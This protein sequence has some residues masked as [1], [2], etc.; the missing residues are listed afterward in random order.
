MHRP[1]AHM[2]RHGAADTISG[3]IPTAVSQSQPSAR[4]V[5]ATANPATARTRR[6]P[7][8]DGKLPVRL[9]V[10][11]PDGGFAISML[12]IP[13]LHLLAHV[14]RPTISPEPCEHR[15]YAVH[16][17]APPLLADRPC[18]VRS[19]SDAISGP[20]HSAAP[21]LRATSRPSGSISNVVGTPG[22]A[23]LCDPRPD[24]ST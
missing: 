4:P 22:M 5:A 16:R 21:I 13:S 7:I 19:I 23:R 1:S 14:E 2:I 24:G 17:S 11:E 3:A 18:I 15:Q 6:S 12:C 20:S 10:G 9:C 8:Q